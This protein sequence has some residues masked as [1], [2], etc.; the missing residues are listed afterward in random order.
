MGKWSKA[1]KYFDKV[2]ETHAEIEEKKGKLTLPPIEG[3]TGFRLGDFLLCR[4]EISLGD[5][6]PE[7]EYLGNELVDRETAGRDLRSVIQDVDRYLKGSAETISRQDGV[8]HEFLRVRARAI[9]N[10]LLRDKSDP[11]VHKEINGDRV[12]L[13]PDF[14]NYARGDVPRLL[15]KRSKILAPARR[16]GVDDVESDD[17]LMVALDCLDEAADIAAYGE[18][19]LFEADIESERS[20]SSSPGSSTLTESL[21]RSPSPES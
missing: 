4:A 11:N 6:D 1:R 3:L 9:E 17:P 10:I 12:R 7:G 19:E 21:V 8:L 16:L 5:W 15:V 20:K 13:Y 2:K 18:M 14:Q